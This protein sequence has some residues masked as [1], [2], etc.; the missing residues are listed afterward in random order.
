MALPSSA[1]RKRWTKCSR[2][3]ATRRASRASSTSPESRRS[4]TA[5]RCRAP[6]V[7]YIILKDWSERG[8]GEDLM[9]LFNKLNADLAA[10]PEADILVM[11][12]P[13]IQGVGNDAG[14]TMQVELGD[15]SF[16]MAKLQSVTN[17]IVANAKTQSALQLVLASFRSNVPQYRLDVDRVKTE[18]LQVSLDQVFAALGGYLGSTYVNQFNQFGRVFQV[19]VQADSQ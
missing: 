11:P 13:P 10:I 19:Y 8:E 18:A 16:D 1:R 3:R 5:R 17:A 7:A 14:F 4:T 2:S 12:P 6:G 9:S 15:G